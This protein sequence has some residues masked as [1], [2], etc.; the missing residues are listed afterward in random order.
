M[1][2]KKL[3]KIKPNKKIFNSIFSIRVENKVR[4]L[5]KNYL[6]SSEKQKNEMEFQKY[7]KIKEEKL[8]Y[9]KNIF[10]TKNEESH[11]NNHSFFVNSTKEKNN[12]NREN[13][14]LYILIGL[15][16]TLLIEDIYG[17]QEEISPDEILLKIINDENLKFEIYRFIIDGI[18]QQYGCVT[19][20]EKREKGSFIS[21]LRGFIYLLKEIK[22][23]GQEFNPVSIEYLKKL[24]SIATK[25]VHRFDQEA[26]GEFSGG[27][28]CFLKMDIN[29]SSDGLS[30]LLKNTGKGNSD[31][32]SE[33]DPI[34]SECLEKKQSSYLIGY[35]NPFTTLNKTDAINNLTQKVQAALD[36][37][38]NDIQKS[39]SDDDKLRAIVT[40]VRRI[41]I[42]HPFPDGNC[43]TIC[44]LFLNSLLISQG[45]SPVILAD[46]NRFDGYSTNELIRDIKRG[47]NNTKNL[48]NNSLLFLDDF[49]LKYCED[50]P[51]DIV[52]R[53]PGNYSQEDKELLNKIFLEVAEDLEDIQYKR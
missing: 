48:L 15:V 3:F 25:N 20:W 1:F 27:W 19:Q 49:K 31:F 34:L 43:R 32:P 5:T 22:E 26:I 16:I 36:K 45:F 47:M 39:Q 7:T 18:K 52:N 28:A 38:S 12:I 46:P 41:E 4:L 8:F 23:K 9:S 2:S 40:C 35:Y 29:L 17:N 33:V 42:I 44:V 11:N 10:S 53:Y 24:H 37:Y 14:F 51:G 30:E 6:N 50:I 21:A 13:K